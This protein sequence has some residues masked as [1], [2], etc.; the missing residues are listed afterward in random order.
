MKSLVLMK[1]YI[2]INNKVNRYCKLKEEIKEKINSMKPFCYACWI[3][4]EKGLL[5]MVVKNFL[6]NW[7]MH[8][9]RKSVIL[10]VKR[11]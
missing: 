3:L 10:V 7:I 6:K 1:K 8:K 2:C 5:N 4:K 11:M 9:Q